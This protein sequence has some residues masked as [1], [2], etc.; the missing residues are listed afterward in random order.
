MKL[1]YWYAEN[2]FDS[3]IY[4]IRAKTKREATRLRTESGG[5]DEFGPVVKVEVEYADGFDLMDMC[6]SE[7]GMYWE[8]E[9]A[10]KAD[11]SETGD[12]VRAAIARSNS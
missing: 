5:D 2:K 11:T 3:N 4:S 6:S 10:L 12:M 8:A 9:A 7:S 1:S